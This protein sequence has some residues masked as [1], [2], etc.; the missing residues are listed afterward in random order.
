[1][2]TPDNIIS[3]LP[4]QTE[5]VI[6][7]Y[8]GGIDSHVLLH[9][10]ASISDIKSKITAIYVHHGLQSDADLWEKHCE[11]VCLALNVRYKCLK[12]NAQKVVGQSPEE[13]ARDQRYQAFKKIVANNDVLLLAQHRE[14]QMETVLLQLFR[15]AGVQGLSGMPLSIAFG[16]GLMCRPFLDVPKQLINEYADENQLCWVEDPSNKS[17][18]FDRNLLRN[19]ILPQLKKRWPALDK[20]IAR[21]ARHCATSH[22][23]SQDIAQKLLNSVCDKADETLSISQLLELEVNKQQLVIRQ[24]F[25]NQCLRMPSEKMLQRIIN[26]VV[27]AKQSANPMVQGRDYCIRRYRDKLYCLKEFYDDQ[28]LQE[29]KWPTSLKQLGLGGGQV[30][31]VKD[32]AE[33]ILK[34]L[35]DNSEVSVRF[36]KGAEKISLPGRRGHHTLKN[37][38]QEKA[39]PPWERNNIPLI[40]LNDDLAAVTGLWI[41][42]DFYSID[43]GPCYQILLLKKQQKTEK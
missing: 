33:G 35:W 12:V 32:A 30:L 1:M 21:S 3:V 41:S 39:I 7:A 2:L 4:P 6:I 31:A 11:A 43:S 18:D 13:V 10:A 26:E 27:A 8:S 38:F 23:L 17:N 16:H 36:R 37:L 5:R 29:K 42:A 20:T 14:D 25:T 40:Y 19:Q 22:E 28:L 34:E 15:G 9:L 24:W